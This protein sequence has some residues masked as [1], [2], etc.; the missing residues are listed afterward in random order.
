MENV[1][2]RLLKLGPDEQQSLEQTLGRIKGV[3]DLLADAIEGLKE[4]DFPSAIAKVSPWVEMV[5]GALADAVPPIKFLVKLFERLTKA[6]DPGA[7]AYLACT[8]AYLQSLQKS[9]QIVGGPATPLL[10]TDE[11]RS[12]LKAL[13]PS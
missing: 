3:T 1:L 12:R 9:T 4:T 6:P 5:G 2:H 7:L 8:S 10:V 13:K 11:I